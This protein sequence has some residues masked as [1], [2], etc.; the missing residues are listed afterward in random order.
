MTGPYKEDKEEG[1]YRSPPKV[2]RYRSLCAEKNKDNN[3]K[4][5]K[6]FPIIFRLLNPDFYK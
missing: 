2:I 6:N 5:F 1:S 4:D 3:C